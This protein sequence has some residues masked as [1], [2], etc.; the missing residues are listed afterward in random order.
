MEG[1]MRRAALSVMV[2]CLAGCADASTPNS[3]GPLPVSAPAGGPALNTIP[4]SGGTGATT[5]PPTNTNTNTNTNTP[6]TT[7]PNTDKPTTGAGGTGGGMAG[8]AP[9]PMTAGMGG[10]PGT[11]PVGM[12]TPA[13]KKDPTIPMATGE[14]PDFQNGSIS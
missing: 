3:S 5:A 4:G 6:P 10:A 2:L 9:T 1:D 11:G 12:P 7:K 13:G 14:C 8:R